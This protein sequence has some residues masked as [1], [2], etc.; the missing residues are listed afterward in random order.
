MPRF[1]I[2]DSGVHQEFDTGAKRD[3]REGKGRYDLIPPAAIHRLAQ[4]YEKGA[5]KYAPRNWEK[6]M[7]FHLFM[8]SALRHAFQY[9][10]GQRDE[11]HLGHA[12]FNLLALMEFE[13]RIAAGRL[14]PKLNDLPDPII[15]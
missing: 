3:Q 8:D 10:H 12:V 5:S 14:D 7:P 9:L 13:D 2:K 4:V 11:D 15:P 1:A 6:G